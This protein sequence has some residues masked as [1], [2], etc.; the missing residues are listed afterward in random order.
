MKKNI[1]FL[2][3]I[4]FIVFSA[5]STHNKSRYKKGESQANFNFPHDKKIEKSFY[6]LGDGGY[7]LPGGTSMDLISK[8]GSK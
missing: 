1:I 8:L 2:T 3:L 7:S 4:I 5:C 6:L